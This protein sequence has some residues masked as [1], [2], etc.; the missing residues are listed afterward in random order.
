MI[1]AVLFDLDETLLVRGEAIKAFISAQYNRHA[2]ALAGID[3]EQYRSRFLALEL[4]TISNKGTVYKRLVDELGITGISAEALLADYR[5]IYPSFATLS[6]GARETLIALRDRG[7]KTGIITNGGAVVQNGKLDS[8]GLASLVDVVLIS[9]TE[10]MEKPDRRLFE[11]AVEQL[12]V[13]PAETVFVGDNAEVDIVGARDAGLVAVWYS[14]TTPWPANLPPAE[15]AVAALPD[16]L[17]I[18]PLSRAA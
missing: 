6:M 17:D 14:A 8:T 13:T 4:D 15:R 9:E 7:L 18:P 2:K 1:K 12:G 11:R 16:L 3:P 10:G 5:A